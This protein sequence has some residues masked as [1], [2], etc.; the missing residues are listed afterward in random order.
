MEQGRSDRRKL[1]AQ[2]AFALAVLGGAALVRRP[3]ADLRGQAALI[4][5]GSRG[6]GLLLARE[7]GRAGCR[8]AICARSS[9]P[10][11]A[12]RR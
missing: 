4:T 6:L 1:A 5:G 9:W 3:M 10:I 11:R 2:A 12:W 7:F 8:V